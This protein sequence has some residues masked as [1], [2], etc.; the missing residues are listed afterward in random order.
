MIWVAAFLSRIATRARRGVFAIGLPPLQAAAL[1]DKSRSWRP[2]ARSRIR[3]GWQSVRRDVRVEV[4]GA[5]QDRNTSGQT[6]RDE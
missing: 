6:S 4:G 3:S 5:I 2:D 1:P